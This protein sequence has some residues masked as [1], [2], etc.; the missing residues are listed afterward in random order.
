MEGVGMEMKV[1]SNLI[2]S[3]REDRGWTQDHLATVAGLSLRTIQ[4]IEK[5]GS[6]SLESVTALASV[7]SV[8]VA[9]LRTGESAPSR[10]RA[11]RL[12]LELPVRLA[13]AVVSGV[14]CALH[15]RWNVVDSGWLV[16]GFGWLDFGIAGALFA[17]AV[18][19]PYLR[20]SPGLVMRALALIGA[21]ALSY[22]CAVMTVL[23]ADA[24]FSVAPVLASFL[25]ASFIGVAIVLVAAKILIPL[26]V[27]AAFWF[28]GLAASLV[29]GAAM[30]A[31]FEVLGD[32]TLSTVVSFCVWHVLACIAIDRGRPSNDAHDGLLAAF[33]RTR[34]RFSI[35]PGWMKLSH[36]TL[37]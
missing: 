22:F 24:W 29:G 13:L 14:L 35:V 36:P 3:K 2:K 15:L 31:G 25:L 11:I 10:E 5:T 32:T 34:G 9:D 1:D 7:L 26:R 8:E 16:L 18:L 6:A 27:T 20:A 37:G 4:R 12:S 28:L 30:Y 23:N 33:T 19:C 21:S 17:V